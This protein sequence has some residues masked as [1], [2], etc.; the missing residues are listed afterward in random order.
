MAMQ[1]LGNGLSAADH[2]EDALSVREAELA[3]K[4]RLGAPDEH[5]L[6]AQN[7]LAGTYTSLG[8]LEE[9][10]CLRENVYSGRLKLFGEQHGYTI[11]AA[12]NYAALL[13]QLNRFEEARSLLR[14]A[15]PIT[16]RVLGDKH[17]VMFRMKKIYAQTLYQDDSA[18]LDDLREA[19]T[20]LE[21]T[22]RTARRVLGSAHPLTVDIEDAL[23]DARAALR[24][25]EATSK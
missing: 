25:R 3:M 6:V 12:N 9:A 23:Q 7:N 10:L 4:R 17:V 5:I 21:G 2:N 20:T 16:R 24:A 8:R 15:M 11:S 13:K 22:E 14:K 18:T 19:V 1:Q